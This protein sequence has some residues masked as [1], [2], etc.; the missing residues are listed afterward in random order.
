MIKLLLGCTSIVCATI[1]LC[2]GFIIAGLRGAAQ[3][4]QING[5]AFQ[6]PLF[7][8]GIIWF[9][10]PLFLLVVGGILIYTSKYDFTEA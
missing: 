10:I 2:T 6:Y 8:I 7:D 5:G 4:S 1:I 9:I 3:S